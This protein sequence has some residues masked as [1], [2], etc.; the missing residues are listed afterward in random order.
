MAIACSVTISAQTGGSSEQLTV[1]RIYGAPSL[2][3]KL[4]EGVQWSP[5]STRISFMQTDSSDPS[6]NELWIMDAAS[7]RKSA[8]L[9]AKQLTHFLQPERAAAIQSTGLGRVAAKDYF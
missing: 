1:E 5:N 9:N 4:S 2:S 6:Q 8:L 7:G 3:G